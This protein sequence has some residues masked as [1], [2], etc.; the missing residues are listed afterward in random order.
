LKWDLFKNAAFSIL[1][2]S[3][4]PSLHSAFRMAAPNSPW[5]SWL[6]NKASWKRASHDC[7]LQGLLPATPQFPF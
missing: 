6:L 3:L 1:V 5:S 7:W 2:L 4:H